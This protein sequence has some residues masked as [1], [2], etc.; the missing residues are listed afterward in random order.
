MAAC[1]E[2]TSS[3]LRASSHPEVRGQFQAGPRTCEGIARRLRAG[4]CSRTASSLRVGR[5]GGIADET[6]ESAPV[7]STTLFGTERASWR[8][9]C[10]LAARRLWS[11]T[12]TTPGARDCE[13]FSRS[14]MT[15]APGRSSTVGRIEH[16]PDAELRR[17][18]DARSLAREV[19]GDRRRSAAVT[20]TPPLPVSGTAADESERQGNGHDAGVGAQREGRSCRQGS[21]IGLDSAIREPKLK[22]G[23]PGAGR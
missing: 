17:A 14:S 11:S 4:R 15:R 13:R 3:T 7:A 1:P 12:M 22:G 23:A 18:D 8:R 21:S 10:S 5:C 2:P 20:M 19:D 6:V 9:F 16:F